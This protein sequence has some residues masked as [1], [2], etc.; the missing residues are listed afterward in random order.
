MLR[1]LAAAVVLFAGVV[2]GLLEVVKDLEYRWR[3]RFRD[4]SKIS[5]HFPY[6]KEMHHNITVQP[7]GVGCWFKMK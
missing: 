7:V 5:T 4:T 1:Q 3:G 2:D 6:K